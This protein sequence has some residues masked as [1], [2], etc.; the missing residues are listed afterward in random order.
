MTYTFER[1]NLRGDMW[2][3]P[4]NNGP[5]VFITWNGRIVMAP[6]WADNTIGRH[7]SFVA[8]G[9]IERGF[10]WSVSQ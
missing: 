10:T 7:I 8:A 1:P 2:M 5:W 3:D 4:W 6:G 9:L